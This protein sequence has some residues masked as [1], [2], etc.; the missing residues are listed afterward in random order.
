M[1]RVHKLLVLVT[2]IGLA[3]CTGPRVS[4]QRPVWV[5]NL[6]PDY[7]ADQYLTGQGMADERTAAEDR[8]RADLANIFQVRGS[9]F[10]TDSTTGS[11]SSSP[12]EDAADQNRMGSFLLT[13]FGN[14]LLYK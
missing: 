13:N 9:E 6:H 3:G 7:T 1:N 14:T 4:D 2:L 8:A 11:A 5:D 12:E 10:T